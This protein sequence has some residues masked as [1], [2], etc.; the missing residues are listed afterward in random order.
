MVA[1]A[2]CSVHYTSQAYTS[3]HRTW[4]DTAKDATCAFGKAAFATGLQAVAQKAATQVITDETVEKSDSLKQYRQTAT[5]VTQI[6]LQNAASLGL[7][8]TNFH[9]ESG[10]KVMLLT[11]LVKGVF[12]FVSNLLPEAATPPTTPDTEPTTPPTPP[13]KDASYFNRNTAIAWLPLVAA[14]LLNA[15]AESKA[16]G[17]KGFIPDWIRNHSLFNNKISENIWW[18]LSLGTQKPSNVSFTR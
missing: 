8:K 11:T 6:A 13:I 3:P 1:V 18:F 16:Q 5:A 10:Q 12:P 14:L 7:K 15:D 9:A 2:L 17:N 4:S